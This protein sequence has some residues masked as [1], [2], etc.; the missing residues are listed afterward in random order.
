MFQCQK[1]QKEFK[2]Q[3][4]LISHNQ[5]CKGAIVEEASPDTPVADVPEEPVGLDTQKWKQLPPPIREHLEKS[6]GNWLNHFEIGAEWKE[7]FGG[8]GIYVHV[9][10]DFSVEYKVLQTPVYD[11]ATRTMARMVPIEH[12]DIRWKSLNN[13]DEA[14]KWLDLVKKK[15]IDD[16]YAGGIRLPNTKTIMEETAQTRED[17]MNSLHL[18]AR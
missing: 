1:C 7:C 12:K 4:G 15:I 16:A 5:F 8:M 13:I 11:N 2:S 6:W 9:P 18:S 3:R 14:K 17:Y 10:K